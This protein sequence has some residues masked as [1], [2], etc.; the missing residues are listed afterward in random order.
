M[1]WRTV[2]RTT[3]W[4]AA[5]SIAALGC[6]GGDAESKPAAAPTPAPAPILP[7]AATADAD[8]LG[9]RPEVKEAPAFVPPAPVVFRASNGMTVWLLERHALPVVAIDVA[10]PVGSA[11]DPPGEGGLAWAS[12]NMLDEGAGTRGALDQIG[13]ASCRERV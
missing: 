11:S 3:G 1:S 12:A 6:G 4:L 9:P 13:R 8:P 5:L 7:P 2:K 10:L